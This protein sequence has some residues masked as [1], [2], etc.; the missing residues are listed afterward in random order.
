MKILNYWD[1]HFLG[2]EKSA[3]V[4]ATVGVAIY[5]LVF[6]DATF[7]EGSILAN[8]VTVYRVAA[9]VATALLGFTGTIVALIYGLIDAER[10]K[11]LRRSTEYKTVWKVFFSTIQASGLLVLVSFIGLIVDH[12]PQ[13]VIWIPIL[14]FYAG[15][16]SLLRV[17]RSVWVLERIIYILA[18]PSPSDR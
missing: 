6:S 12:Q 8:R 7:L 4:A 13:P 16:L 1:R 9:G 11:Y 3:A 15:L 2:C 18:L 17:A 10:L 5:V 14:F